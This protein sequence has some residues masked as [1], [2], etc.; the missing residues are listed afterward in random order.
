MIWYGTKEEMCKICKEKHLN[1]FAGCCEVC[2]RIVT[3]CD[4]EE[5][6]N[7]CKNDT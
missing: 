4:K 5:T 6:K 3:I 1:D 2:E 7:E